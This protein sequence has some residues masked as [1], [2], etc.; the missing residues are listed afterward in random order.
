[1]FALHR[2]RMFHAKARPHGQ[3]EKTDG[4]NRPT[5]YPKVTGIDADFK[6]TCGS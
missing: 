6:I 2:V 1:M 5:S 4:R 3:R